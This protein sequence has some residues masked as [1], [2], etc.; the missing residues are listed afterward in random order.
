M[1]Y[2]YDEMSPDSP[3][4]VLDHPARSN[5][6]DEQHYA[7]DVIDASG[8]FSNMQQSNAISRTLPGVD[9]KKLPKAPVI[10]IK[11]PI[12]RALGNAS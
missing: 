8:A 12:E 2:Q 10:P 6:R 3:M 7:G 4:D 11:S 1:A 9:V 5:M